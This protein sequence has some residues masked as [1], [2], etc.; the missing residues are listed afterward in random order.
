M[1]EGPTA[2]VYTLKLSKFVG[3]EIK[4]IYWRSK[5]VK[6][7]KEDLVGKI[8]DKVDC[9]GKNIF[10]FIDEFVIRIHLML[11]GSIHFYK[12]NEKLLK[13]EKQVRLFIKTGKGKIVVYNAPI[14]EINDYSLFEK[15]KN[16]LGPDPLR[17]DWNLEEALSR[18]KSR[19][20]NKIKIVLLDQTCIAGIGNI[21]ANEILFRAKIHPDSLVGKIP[22]RKLRFLLKITENLSKEFFERKKKRKRIKSILFV[23]NKFNKPCPICGN[24]IKFYL[25]EPNKRKIFVCEKCQVL[26][27]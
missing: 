8:I 6:V 13:P 16:Q 24:P 21:L 19:K 11:Y 3:S 23:Y 1:V 18:L 2:K 26:Y 14:I 9:I 20:N 4:E 5:K 17:K 27:D 25:Q 10:I 12:I 7:K 15:L 22:E